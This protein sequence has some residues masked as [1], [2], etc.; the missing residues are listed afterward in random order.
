M[1]GASPTL[2][3]EWS[4]L[5]A[6]CTFNHRHEEIESLR[7]R[8]RGPIRWK[9]LYSILLRRTGFNPYCIDSSQAFAI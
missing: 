9:L 6:A 7:A 5:E 1:P 3:R 4:L 8:L 2:E